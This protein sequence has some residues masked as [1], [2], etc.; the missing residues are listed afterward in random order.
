M[1]DKLI[2]IHNYI[3]EVRG[4]RVMLDSDLAMLYGVETRALK[5]A[6][7]RNIERFPSDFMFELSL[8][9]ADSLLKISRSQIVTLKQGKNTK[10]KPFAFTEQ[11]VAMLSS[12]LH[13]EVAI[14]V[15]I[16][17]MR[18]FIQVREALTLSKSVSAEINELRAKVDLLAMQQEENLE[19]VNDLSED[20]RKDIDNLYVAI[21]ELALKLDDKK[22][23]PRSRIGFK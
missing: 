19:A 2:N 22:A 13:S 10:Y 18:A 21:G 5:Q 20:V 1:N 14:K 17:I 12:V 11:G 15:N 3:C 23:T 7:R 6:V 8:E 4:R 16:A 9:E